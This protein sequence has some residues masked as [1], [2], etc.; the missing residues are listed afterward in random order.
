MEN[1]EKTPWLTLGIIP[2]LKWLKWE[3]VHSSFKHIIWQ[4]THEDI[5]FSLKTLLI[6]VTEKVSKCKIMFYNMW[7]KCK[8]WKLRIRFTLSYSNL[9]VTAVN[10]G[11]FQL[12]YLKIPWMAEYNCRHNFLSLI[13]WSLTP[14]NEFK[15]RFHKKR[16]PLDSTESTT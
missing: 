9:Q 5:P 13:Q 3:V 2:L 4:Y 8:A 1:A 7:N 6:D 16:F 11:S 14:Q 12:T 10:H 15:I